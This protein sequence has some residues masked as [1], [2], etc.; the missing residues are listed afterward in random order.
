[1]K[2]AAFPPVRVSPDL[3]EAAEELLDGGETLSAFVEEAI[4]R[5]VEFR[6]AQRA[7]VARGIASADAARSSGRYVSATAVLG[8]LDRRLVKARRKA[9]GS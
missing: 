8:K 2:T 7:F 3:R 1:M 9:A 4:R 6:Q 5:N